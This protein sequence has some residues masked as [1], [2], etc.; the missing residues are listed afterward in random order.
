[1]SKRAPYK[2][3][4]FESKTDKGKFTKVCY[5]M[6]CSEAWKE[7]NLRQRGLYLHIKSK[8]TQKSSNSVVIYENDNDI[9]LPKEEMAGLYG[10]LRTFRKDKDKLIQCGF[11]Y[12][13][14]NGWYTRQA[15]IYGFS[16]G[17]KTYTRIKG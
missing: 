2:N 3:R 6:M 15:N 16:S 5:D 13:V 9:S 11:I 1:M 17:W 4:P 14:R 10:D 8:Y 12:L 7:L